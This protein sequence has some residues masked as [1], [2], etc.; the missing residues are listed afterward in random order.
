MKRFFD[1]LH[2]SVRHSSLTKPFDPF[3]F[4]LRILGDIRN[5]KSTLF[6]DKASR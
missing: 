2:K 1:F 5:R 6:L 4:W 3:R